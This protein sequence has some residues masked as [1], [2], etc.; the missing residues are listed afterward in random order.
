MVGNKADIVE[1]NPGRREV[2]F[3]DAKYFAECEKISFKESSA[4]NNVNVSDIFENLIESIKHNY[5]NTIHYRNR[6]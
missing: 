4:L 1:K 3:E 6:K 5:I 2:L